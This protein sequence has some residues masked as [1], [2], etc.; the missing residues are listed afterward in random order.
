MAMESKYKQTQKLL[1]IAT[2]VG[3]YSNKEVAKKAGL[4]ESS[5]SLASRWRNGKALAT[6]RQMQYFINE[7]GGQLKRRNTHLFYNLDLN[8]A[9]DDYAFDYCKIEG[10]EI[11]SHKIS[12]CLKVVP[13]GKIQPSVESIKAYKVVI[14]EAEKGYFFVPL[15]RAGLFSYSI[16][17]NEGVINGYHA[18]KEKWIHGDAENSNWFFQ[19]VIKCSDFDELATEFQKYMRYLERH[20]EPLI[21]KP[22]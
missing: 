14:I 1:R 3:G 19:A 4:K 16:E 12:S 9:K 6:E 18:Q 7:Y 22:K 20:V 13:P 17:N 8:E 11:F 10:E 2:E 21:R 15:I 5:V